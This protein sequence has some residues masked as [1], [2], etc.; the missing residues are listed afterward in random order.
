MVAAGALVPDLAHTGPVDYEHLADVVADRVLT[1]QQH[2]ADLAARRTAALA[3]MDDNPD[4]MAELLAEIPDETADFTLSSSDIAGF[5][6][7]MMPLQ[8]RESYLHGKAAAHIG[9][10][11]DGD[12]DRC[13]AESIKH[14]IPG[15]M[16]KGMCSTLHKEATGFAPGRHS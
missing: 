4:R 8:L 15:R 9:W 7:G 12:F 1:R 10:G 14:G 16:R 2:A 3:V 11:T 5:V 13:V 6:T